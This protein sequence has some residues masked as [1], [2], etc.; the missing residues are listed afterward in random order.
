MGLVLV[1]QRLSIIDLSPAGHQPMCDA[2]TGNQLVFNGEI[3]NY[4]LLRDELKASGVSFC[5]ASDTEVILQGYAAWGT[6]VFSRLR[7]MFALALYDSVRRTLILARDR[8]G[9]KPLYYCM[10]PREDVAIC[11]ASEI[12]ALLASTLVEPRLSRDAL[13]GYLVTGYVTDPLT[14]LAQARSLL[15]GHVMVIDGTGTICEYRPFWSPGD[16]RP[17][18]E[19]GEAAARRVREKLEDAVACHLVSDVPLGAFLSGGIDSTT[20]V[21]IMK[22]VSDHRVRTF[23][24]VFDDPLLSEEAYS[25]PIARQLG[26]EHQEVRVREADFLA[27][28]DDALASLDQPSTDAVNSYVVSRKCKEAGLTVAIAGTGGDELFGG[29][30]SFRRVPAALAALRLFRRLPNPL[31]GCL[32]AIAHRVLL[33]SNGFMPS[34]GMRAKLVSLLGLPADPLRVYQLSRAVLLPEVCKGLIEKESDMLE[35]WGLPEELEQLIRSASGGCADVRQQISLFEQ[36]CYLSNQLL[37]DT[38]SVSMAVSLEVRV[39]FLDHELIETVAR[40][41]PS[42]LFGGSASKQFLVD[43]VRDILPRE[44]YHRRKQGFVLPIGRWTSGPLAGLVDDTLLDGDVVGGAGLVPEQV[45]A[46]L[47]NCRRAGDRIFYNR[48]WSL[49]VLTDWC[50]RNKVRAA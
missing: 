46:I 44:A 9:I 16:Q 39:P 45:R 11:F 19:S 22:R 14:I 17:A 13:A 41:A 36:H 28:L 33:G 23:S 3:Y 7:G 35:T 26:T 25:R 29:Y 12:R 47:V 38:D 37:R 20:L 21:A 40:T 4:Q 10:N 42:L 24:L 2:L 43:A 1:H 32:Q 48:L 34:A 31:Q 30:T 50:R 6:A 18:V 27:L 15:P 8:I 5:S 49:F